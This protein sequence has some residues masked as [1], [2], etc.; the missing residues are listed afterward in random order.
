V[1]R[2]CACYVRGLAALTR[3]SCAL[4]RASGDSVGDIVVVVLTNQL[5]Q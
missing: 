3:S 5:C 1:C 2:V 4:G